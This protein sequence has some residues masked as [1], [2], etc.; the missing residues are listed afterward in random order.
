[1]MLAIATPDTQECI[2]CGICFSISGSDVF[3]VRQR[4]KIKLKNGAE[5]MPQCMRIQTDQTAYMIRAWVH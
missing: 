1:M 4:V 3:R 5:F 2:M